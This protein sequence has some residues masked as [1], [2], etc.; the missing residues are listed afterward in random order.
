MDIQ[1]ILPALHIPNGSIVSKETGQKQY[2]LNTKMRI[3][4]Q[5]GNKKEILASDNTKFIINDGDANVI[6]FDTKLKWY[7]D[8]GTL[9]SY[10]DAYLEDNDVW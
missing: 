6:N 10:L 3:F 4:D 8:V 9:Y 2:T 1:V 7:T 5:N